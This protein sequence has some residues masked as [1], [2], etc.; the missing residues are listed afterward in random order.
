MTRARQFLRYWLPALAWAA[1]LLALAGDSASGSNTETLIELV[2]K[3][4]FGE[5]RFQTIFILNYTSRKT[6]HIGA[7]GLLAILN[8]R[9]IRGERSGWNLRWSIQAVL[10]ALAVAVADECR[11]SF[12]GSRSGSAV[13]V[14]FDLWGAAVSQFLVSGRRS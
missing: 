4:I 9:A 10:F 6:A 12:S 3:P 1:V 8:F 2:L 7:Y 5:M 14:L 11:Q 13:D